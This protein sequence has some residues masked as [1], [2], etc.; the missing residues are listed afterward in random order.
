MIL[1]FYVLDDFPDDTSSK[2][3]DLFSNLDDI[4]VYWDK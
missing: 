4:N 2:N 1:T 3:K